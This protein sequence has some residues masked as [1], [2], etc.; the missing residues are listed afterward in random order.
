MARL[1]VGGFKLCSFILFLDL[2]QALNFIRLKEPLFSG[3]KQ[4]YSQVS[5]FIYKLL[6]LLHCSFQTQCIKKCKWE[7]IRRNVTYCRNNIFN[8]LSTDQREKNERGCFGWV[9]WAWDVEADRAGSKF[10]H[11]E[12]WELGPIVS[13]FLASVLGFPGGSDGKESACNVG[14][15]GSIPGL[16]GYPGE[17]HGKPLQYS[18]LRNSHGQRS[19]VGFSPWGHKE[20]T[21]LSD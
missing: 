7:T 6:L 11:Y 13:P 14:D 9:K 8:L 5:H 17:G 4:S 20:L 3:R 15:L 18:C 1:W 16:G 19:L 10:G 2:Q 21:R 12:S